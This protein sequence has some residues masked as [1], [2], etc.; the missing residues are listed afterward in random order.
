MAIIIDD[1]PT[2]KLP[3]SIPATKYHQHFTVLS[4]E[5]P[6]NVELVLEMKKKN[7][8]NNT[9]NQNWKR[10]GN[11]QHTLRH[12]K[13]IKRRK[14]FEFAI[15]KSKQICK[16]KKSG[17]ACNTVYCVEEDKKKTFTCV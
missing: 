14:H 16:R 11:K 17:I 10:N 2:T 9:T 7:N 8:N 6:M 13:P 15:M 4:K 1:Q 3:Q 12:V 5:M